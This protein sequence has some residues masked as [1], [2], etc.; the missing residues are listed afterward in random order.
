MEQKELFHFAIL[1]PL[2]FYSL[3]TSKGIN[4]FDVLSIRPS[5]CRSIIVGIYCLPRDLFWVGYMLKGY[6]SFQ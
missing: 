4:Y 6:E 1:D 2:A 3:F 5:S